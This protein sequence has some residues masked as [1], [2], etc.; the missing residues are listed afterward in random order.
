MNYS[1]IDS[2]RDS[3]FGSPDRIPKIPT[4]CILL[5]ILASSLV[6]PAIYSGDEVI[7][8]YISLGACLF[9]GIC[10]FFSS[11]R[12][13]GAIW[14]IILMVFSAYFVGSPILPALIFGGL[15][16]VGLGSALI[17]SASKGQ[18]LIFTL[19]FPAAY[20]LAFVI[21]RSSVLA[22]FSLAL[23]FPILSMGLAGRLSASKT[24]SIVTCAATVVILTVSVTV[25]AIFSAYGQF[26]R[27]VIDTVI[28]VIKADAIALTEQMLVSSGQIELTEAFKRELA[29]AVDLYVNMSAGS[30]IA[31]TLVASYISHSIHCN[32]FKSFAMDKYLTEKS[33]TLTVSVSA[34]IVFIVSYILSFTTDSHGNISLTAIVGGNLAVILAPVLFITGLSAIKSLPKKFGLFGFII[35]IALFILIFSMFSQLPIILALIGAFSIIFINVDSWAKEHYGKGENK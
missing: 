35:M 20:A 6:I 7:A 9:C 30:L 19:V 4:L 10:L 11:K 24:T 23:L 34:A 8:F 25:W 5:T 31:V 26:N 32:L 14:T 13:S 1:E 16:S 18:A 3:R 27:E 12:I 15:I 29:T 2:A 28:D 17:R 33:T 21:T 22:V